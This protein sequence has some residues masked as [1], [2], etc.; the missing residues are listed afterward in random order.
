MKELTFLAVG[1]CIGAI[2]MK[3]RRDTSDLKKAVEALRPAATN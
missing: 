1:F 2:W 3:S